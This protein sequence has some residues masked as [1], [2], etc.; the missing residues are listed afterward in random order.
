[1]IVVN[2]QPFALV[3]T[4]IQHPYLGI[5][6]EPHVVQL[7]GKGSYTLTHQRVFSKTAD[8]FSKNISEEDFRLIKMLDEVDDD[9]VFKKFNKDLKRKIRTAEFLRYCS[10]EFIKEEIR[11][12]LEEKMHKVLLK[13]RGKTIYKNGNDSNPTSINI[14]VSEVQ[15]NI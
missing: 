10:K 4:F 1:M 6:L 14:I 3:Y 12:F 7:N 8:Y 2:T 5:L 11:P 13:M 15:A 9:F